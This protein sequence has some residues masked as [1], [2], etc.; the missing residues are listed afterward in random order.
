MTFQLIRDLVRGGPST[1]SADVLL[2]WAALVW[3]NNSILFGVLYWDSTRVGLP[4]V[5][6]V[7]DDMAISLP[8][9]DEPR[10]CATGLEPAFVDYLYIGITN[11]LAFSPT[12][13]MPLAAWGSSHDG[14]AVIVLVRRDH[15]VIA[16]AVNMA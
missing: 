9:T 15:L 1:S 16:R 7:R 5:R 3:V 11:G 8:S 6:A 12:D 10:G 2:W 13:A 14:N 4:V